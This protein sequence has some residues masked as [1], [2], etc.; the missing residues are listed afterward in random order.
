M[1]GGTHDVP[2][3]SKELTVQTTKRSANTLVTVVAAEE[4]RGSSAG[5]IHPDRQ[6]RVL[7]TRRFLL[8]LQLS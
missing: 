8:T 2:A 7:R 4:Q 6:S 1:H 5:N 3:D